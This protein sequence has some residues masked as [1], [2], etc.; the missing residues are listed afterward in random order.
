[1]FVYLSCSTQAISERSRLGYVNK[2]H[3]TADGAALHVRHGQ[4]VCGWLALSSTTYQA[5]YR[6]IRPQQWRRLHKVLAEEPALRACTAEVAASQT[7]QTAVSSA[8]ARAFQTVDE[9]I[10]DAC[11]GT[12]QS[13]GSTALVLLRIGQRA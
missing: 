12:R 7:E 4:C 8:L 5:A 6:A 9:E 2:Q 1:M 13:A 11:R 3:V 10:L